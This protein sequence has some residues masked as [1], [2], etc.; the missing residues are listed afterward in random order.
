MSKIKANK[1]NKETW[2]LTVGYATEI[3]EKLESHSRCIG[4]IFEK[5]FQGI[6][7]SKD[8]V[9]FLYDCTEE[10]DLVYG[11]SRQLGYQVCIERGLVK[12]LLKGEDVHRY[13][14]ISTVRFVIFPYKLDNGKAILYTEKEIGTLFPKGYDYLKKCEDILRNREKVD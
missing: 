7:T 5:I 3:L 14:H 1:L 13:E 11:Y 6:A 2:V 8:D 9:Y 12:P 4:D 10:N